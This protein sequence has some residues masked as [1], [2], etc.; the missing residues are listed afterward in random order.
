MN[1]KIK[2]F[3]DGA[4][5]IGKLNKKTDEAIF[6]A[7]REGLPENEIK[8]S[9]DCGNG[10]TVDSWEFTDRT[11]DTIKARFPLS[12][13]GSYRDGIIHFPDGTKYGFI[14]TEKIKEEDDGK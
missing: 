14:I 5:R 9:V 6:A 1:P 2:R 4:R 3:L 8:V 11:E 10:D 13:A 12:Y 7:W